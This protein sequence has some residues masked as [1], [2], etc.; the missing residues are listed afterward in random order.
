M[1]K[2]PQQKNVIIKHSIII[3]MK[4]TVLIF[5]T[6]LSLYS[7]N[8]VGQRILDEHLLNDS[9]RLSL[10]QELDQQCHLISIS[11]TDSTIVDTL[12]TKRL[13]GIIEG[14]SD[15]EYISLISNSDGGYFIYVF[16][17]SETGEFEK[18]S[19]FPV[20]AIV[21]R[22]TKIGFLNQTSLFF[23]RGNQDIIYLLKED[24]IIEEY[25]RT[26]KILFDQQ[27]FEAEQLKRQEEYLEQ[28][29]EPQIPQSI[30]NKN[31]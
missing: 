7:F 13:S 25:S 5:L 19:L 24:G 14:I 17:A 18:Y 31:K 9:T 26:D 27:R 21:Q 3:N 16:R 11:L 2:T 20:S 12:W 15:G 23:S 4:H 22:S 10:Q 29:K 1:T 8:V 30:N 28:K 6:I